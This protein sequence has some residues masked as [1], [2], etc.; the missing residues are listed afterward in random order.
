MWA[1]SRGNPEEIRTVEE[2][3]QNW[4]T[5]WKTRELCPRKRAIKQHSNLKYVRLVL[6]FHIDYDDID[7][8]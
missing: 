8:Y 1:M 3:Y 7:G 2:E 4:K 5:Q 6:G